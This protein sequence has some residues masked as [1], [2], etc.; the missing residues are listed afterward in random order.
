MGQNMPPLPTRVILA[1]TGLP[2]DAN[3]L[4]QHPAEAASWIWHPHKLP[5]ETAVLRF[6]LRFALAREEDLLLHVTGDQRFQLR[7]DGRDA[8]FGPD[9]CDCEHWTVQ[10]LRLPLT[11]GGH[12]LEALVW[13]IGEPAGV[14]SRIDAAGR[15][16]V[17]PPM[18]QMSWRGGFLLH[19]EGAMSPFLTTGE[20]PWMVEDLT[21]AVEM[22]PAAIRHY[23]DVGPSFGFNLKR[24]EEREAKLAVVVVSPFTAN[25][26]GVR[27]PGWCLYPAN[28]PEQRR[29][30]WAG[31]R[32]RA[33]RP[34]VE[35]APIHRDETLA[36]E[37]AV[38]QQMISE[39]TP[40]TIPPHTKLT[41]L[42]DLE[43]YYCGYPVT[44]VRGGDGSLIEWSWAEALYEEASFAQVN[45]QSAK[46]HRDEIEDKVFVG[47]GDQWQIGDAPSTETPSLW[48]RSGRYIRVRVIAAEAPLV[49]AHLGLVTTGYPLDAVG[50]WKS[51][52]ATW[53]SL[54]PLF[55]RSYQIGA[56]E[57]WV[58]TPYY[59]QM[60]YV[61]D[62]LFSALSNYAWFGDVHLS[63][64]SIQLFE[65][66]RKASGF[67]AERYPSAWR[68][69]SAT[70]SLL[71]PLM[72]RD[73]AW[74]RNDAPFVRSMLPGL[75]SVLSEF[76]ALIG[77]DGLLHQ[78]PGWPF[79]DWV[80]GW[81]AGC[82]PGV[83][84]G[85]SS[86]INLYWVLALQAVA[87]VEEAYGDSLL[88]RR[89]REM[90]SSVFA[91]IMNRYWDKGRGLVLDA[92]G[93][94]KASE[95]AQMYALLTG[96]LEP[97]KTQACLD[98]LRDGRDLARATISASFFLLDALYRH[99]DETEFHRRLDFW[100]ALP[101][102]G[103]TATPEGPEPSR[104]DSHPWGSHPAWHTL[105]S[106][107]G[108]RPAAAGF[109]R[110]RIAPLPGPF[111]Y[112][113]AN[114][115]H[116]RGTIQVT[117]RRTPDRPA[118]FDVKLPDDV[119]GCLVFEGH[120]V[121][122]YPGENRLILAAS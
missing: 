10:T 122:L 33:F 113:E 102:R 77:E 35:D 83:R 78:V 93:C 97:G 71:W 9:R 2:A 109:A 61:G 37:I 60:S 56:H 96:L 115:G 36:P 108:V 57:L 66:S 63:R 54:M 111:D 1:P 29:E 50:A 85:D 90:A 80:P 25:G 119:S 42:W 106:I 79:V 7:C 21:D 73:Y 99:G 69:E 45:E 65:W 46:G 114:V 107:A 17:Y 3:S 72:V 23:H 75:R 81:S 6:R 16:A 4:R 39:G 59:E 44:R 84:E 18:A 47:F 53:D 20:A 121:D 51:S 5:T 48:W 91:S 62:N 28:L 12:E 49:L 55:Q 13:F 43:N 64:R 31:G 52:D 41:V 58:D 34:G 74:W 87:D 70:Y 105:A 76:E 100:R 68:Q 86:I 88:G 82:G 104:S 14:A 22:K 116:P 120:A 98:A 24:W 32:I 30:P 26:Y 103:F 118:N 95:H 40:I 38:W 8:T 27:R 89:D 67:V 112:F 94:E 11:S 92:R 15:K 101:G 110:V 117:F 19:A